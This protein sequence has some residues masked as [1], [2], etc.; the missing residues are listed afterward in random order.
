MPDASQSI[1]CDAAVCGGGIVGLAVA[2]ALADGGRRVAL[3]ERR[4]PVRERGALGFDARSV[5]LTPPS[6]AFLR[7][8]CDID[9]A[10]LAAIRRMRVWEHDG[11]AELRFLAEP[12]ESAN[13]APAG[14]PLAWVA[15]NS[16]LAARLWRR[17]AERLDLVA[18]ALVCAAREA[19]DGMVLSCRGE[20]GDVSVYARLIVA[21]DGADSRLRALAG[22]CLRR[23]ASGLAE[24]QR[25]LA[26]VARLR[27][28]HGGT[29]WQRFGATG[30]VA[31]L[32]LADERCVAVIW[33]AAA[34][35]IERLESLGDEG[36]RAALAAE[37]E[38][39]GGGV[40][41]VDRRF[42]FALE[43]ALATNLNPLPRVVL[44]GDA[45]RTLH[46]LAGQGVN[47]GLEDARAIAATAAAA[48]GDLGALG[49][50]RDYARARRARSKFMLALMRALLTAYCGRRAANPW[51]RWARNETLRWIDR[52]A[53][54]KAQL[55]REAM[56]LGPLAA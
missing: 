37:T 50:W 24:P 29:A 12:A 49:R 19:S 4:P 38:G 45:A 47:I 1:A 32:P 13:P 9:D 21:A 8:V 7:T 54:L 2:L 14:A 46:P 25:A 15:E 31:L 55:I 56:G 36:F 23:M 51:R 30:P 43:Q 40:A 6:V 27:E 10:D 33:S 16:V 39:A 22:G 28:A 48:N 41:A 20:G 26:T 17:A 5:A 3:V 35:A 42:S 44:A 52:Q 11:N 53:P 18:P 34:S